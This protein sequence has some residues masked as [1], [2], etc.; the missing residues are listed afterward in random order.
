[1]TITVNKQDRTGYRQESTV[2]YSTCEYYFFQEINL[3][4][5]ISQWSFISAM[6]DS[7]SKKLLIYRK[8]LPTGACT[9]TRNT[10]QCQWRGALSKTAIHGPGAMGKTSKGQPAHGVTWTSMLGAAFFQ[11]RN[12]MTPLITSAPFAKGAVVGKGNVLTASFVWLELL[13]P[14]KYKKKRKHLLSYRK[15][16]LWTQ[17]CH[18]EMP[19]IFNQLEMD[20]SSCIY[21]P[22]SFKYLKLLI[23]VRYRCLILEFGIFLSVPCSASKWGKTIEKNH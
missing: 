14:Q 11:A 17:D 8:P 1:M 6:H 15:V 9:L 18:L 20:L 2:W 21:M 12:L 13:L 4:T 5:F 23:G 7:T 19:T 22:M 16:L 10:P 3:V